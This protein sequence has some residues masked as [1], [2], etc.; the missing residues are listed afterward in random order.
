M[1]NPW[2]TGS[3]TPDYPSNPQKKTPPSSKGGGVFVRNGNKLGGLPTRQKHGII[4][5]MVVYFNE[6][7]CSTTSAAER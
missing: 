4:N 6:A 2:P 5:L 7:V 3:R 1:L